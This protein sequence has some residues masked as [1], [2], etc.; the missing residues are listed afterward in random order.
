[1]GLRRN[2]S[3]LEHRLLSDIALTPPQI[4]ANGKLIIYAGRGP[5]ASVAAGSK[6]EH[7]HEE[8][9]LKV[10][11][12]LADDYGVK[13]LVSSLFGKLDIFLELFFPFFYVD[14]LKR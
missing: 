12:T 5:S 1:L 7:K 14:G 8:I 2:I 4:D 9:L 11:G 10:D 6:Y 3:T 13:Y